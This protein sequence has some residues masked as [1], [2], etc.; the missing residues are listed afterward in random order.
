MDRYSY[1]KKL[2]NNNINFLNKKKLN[3]VITDEVN[4]MFVQVLIWGFFPLLYP[5][6]EA[7]A[8]LG[9]AYCRENRLSL[10][11][12]NLRK[13]LLSWALE[14]F[15]VDL[16]SLNIWILIYHLETSLFIPQ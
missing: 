2:I 8:P 1:L 14:Y 16:D 3:F 11:L 5:T 10:G 12:D 4:Q 7:V 13:L 6:F 9:P 15:W